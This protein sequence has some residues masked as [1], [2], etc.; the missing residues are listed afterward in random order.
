[1]KEDEPFSLDPQ[2]EKAFRVAYLVAGFIRKTLTP[3]ENIELDNWVTSSMDNQRLFEKLIEE[4]KQDEWLQQIKAIATESALERAKAKISIVKPIKKPK[5]RSLWPFVAAASVLVPIIIGLIVTKTKQPSTSPIV[6]QPSYDIIPGKDQATLTLADGRI[7]GLDTLKN[8]KLLTQANRQITNLDSGLLAY[9]LVTPTL[10]PQAEVFNVLT[11]PAGGQYKVVLPD[12]T[13]VWLN[14]SSSLKYPTVFGGSKRK[15]ELTG[16]GYFEVAK[17]P[18]FPFEVVAN[19]SSILVLGTHFNVNAYNDEPLLSV[20]LA[21]GAVRLNNTVV[22]KPGDQGN[23]AS[24]GNIEKVKANLETTLA[25]KD[26]VFD[27]KEAPIDVLM[28]QVGRW[29]NAQIIYDTKITDHFN[30]QIPRNV[31]VSKLLHLLEATG[32][33]HFKIENNIIRV[34]K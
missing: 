7:V 21:E 18:M 3:A 11:V 24:N 23:I 15:V 5:V 29:Y 17:D 16:E 32:S 14:A 13:K 30:A 19:R 12:G 34:M 27:F 20:A 10:L 6:Q 31:P 8:A 4:K 22:L 25:W 2:D 9:E 1:M 26:G 33:V 28:R